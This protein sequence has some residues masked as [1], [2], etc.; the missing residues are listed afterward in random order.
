MRA[1]IRP[2]VR[3]LWRTAQALAALGLLAALPSAAHGNYAFVADYLLVSSTRVNATLNDFVYRIRVV[4]QGAALR[5]ATATVRSLAPWMEIRDNTVALGNL[6]GIGMIMVDG[7]VRTARSR[8]TP[9]A[10]RV[11]EVVAVRSLSGQTLPPRRCI[12]SPITIA[13]RSE[14]EPRRRPSRRARLGG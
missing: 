4:N 1:T 2:S 13:S 9:P 8:N 7:V 3:R 11:P 5:N 6:P 10:I 12:I 14:K